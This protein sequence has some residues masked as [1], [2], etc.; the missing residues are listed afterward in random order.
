MQKNWYEN[1]FSGVALDMW[2]KAVTPAQ[3][4]AE[5]DFLEKALQ[6][7]RNGRVLDNPCGN[8]RHALEL[9]ARG[10]RVTGIDVSAEFIAEATASAQARGL[11]AEFQHRDMRDVGSTAEFDGVFCFG[12]SFSYMDYDGSCAFLAAVS[13]ALKP[14]GRFV[15]ESGIM[16]ESLLPKLERRRWLQLGDIVFLSS[17]E[18]DAVESRLD[19]Q[20]TFIRDGITDTR[21]ASSY[22][23]TVAEL[24][25]M[26]SHAGL[27]ALEYYGSVDRQPY[28]LGSVR[29][30]LVAAKE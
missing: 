7:P 5:A 20:Y 11:D 21:E 1:F 14:G 9:A 30:L 17:N 28:E 15:L 2:R 4:L 10:Y 29:M 16:A 12:N 27:H 22:I 23:Y 25:R 19:I 6:L 26:L 8:G 24:R 18:Y 13:L 3:T